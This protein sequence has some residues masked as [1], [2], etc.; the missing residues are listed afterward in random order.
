M[1]TDY[2]KNKEYLKKYREEHRDYYTQ[3][4]LDHKEHL[5]SLL[6]APVTCDCGFT[7]AKVNIKRHQKTKLHLKRLN[8]KLNDQ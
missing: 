4:N 6:M 2:Q 7:C 8:L 3:Y 5:L 1:T